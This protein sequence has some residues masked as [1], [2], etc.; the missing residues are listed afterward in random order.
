R[1]D[2]VFVKLED[3]PPQIRAEASE[4]LVRTDGDQA[5]FELTADD[6][7]EAGKSIVKVTGKMGKVDHVAWVQLNVKQPGLQ[8]SVFPELTLVAGLKT[9]IEVRV[10]R[11]GSR[12]PVQV[13]IE[14]LPEK[15]AFLPVSIA[16]DRDRGGLT[17]S[18]SE[19]VEPGQS[20]FRLVGMMGKLKDVSLVSLDVKERPKPPSKETKKAEK[21]KEKSKEP[22]FP[23]V[24]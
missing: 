13:K 21:S 14:G 18:A 9:S 10:T 20:K 8:V 5:Q 12:L 16:G 24:A 22:I 6:D 2:P 17:I 3:L 4:V 15:C 1:P 7:I 19:N 23:N 11:P